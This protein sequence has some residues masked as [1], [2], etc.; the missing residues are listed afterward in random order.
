MLIS[1]RVAIAGIRLLDSVQVRDVSSLYLYNDSNF[2]SQLSDFLTRALVL[3][4]DRHCFRPIIYMSQKTFPAPYRPQPVPRVLQ[5][6]KAIAQPKVATVTNPSHGLPARPKPTPPVNSRPIQMKPANVGLT[7][8]RITPP[9]APPQKPRIVQPKVNA[10]RSI[11]LKPNYK[12]YKAWLDKQRMSTG[13]RGTLNSRLALAQR[14]IAYT[15]QKL[16]H[17]AGNITEQVKQS[18][19]YSVKYTKETYDRSPALSQKLLKPNHG[20]EDQ[21]LNHLLTQAITA[22]KTRAGNCDHFAAVSLFYLVEHAPKNSGMLFRLSVGTSGNGHSVV[23][24]ADD[25]WT[26]DVPDDQAAYH[27]AVVVDAWPTHA[28]ACAWAD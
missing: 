25:N 4:Q 19:E 3:Y 21:L 18:M 8:T 16:I 9:V 22:R 10:G 24:Y 6:K 27:T 23:I 26:P 5:T 14:A 1:T 15:R 20:R 11:Q 17:G 2:Q 7:K 12:D 13:L 28:F